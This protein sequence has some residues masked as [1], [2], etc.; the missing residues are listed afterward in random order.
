MSLAMA[1]GG[2]V[3]GTASIAILT[4]VVKTGLDPYAYCGVNWE[5][6]FDQHT[7]RNIFSNP[8]RYNEFVR[9]LRDD[10]SVR[11]F[12]YPGGT[13]VNYFFMG[14]PAT[15]WLPVLKAITPGISSA[16]P[17]DWIEVGEFFEFIKA[18]NF[19]VVLQVNTQYWF[20]VQTNEIKPVALKSDNS[21]EYRDVID[22]VGLQH[23]AAAVDQLA[24]YLRD[25]NY[26]QYVLK[27]EIGNEEN[28]FLTSNVYAS[29]VDE[30]VT[31]IRAVFPAAQIIATGPTGI[32]GDT[33]SNQWTGEVISHLNTSG[34]MSNIAGLVTHM[35]WAS[36]GTVVDSTSYQEYAGYM[37]FLPDSKTQHMWYPLYD[38][39]YHIVSIIGQMLD[40]LATW[41][42][43]GKEIWFTEYRLGGLTEY[44]STALAGAIGNTRLLAALVAAPGV[45]GAC[46]HSLLHGGYVGT[47]ILG[48]SPASALG[49]YKLVYYFADSGVTPHMVGTPGAEGFNLTARLAKGNV[50]KT[51]SSNL[52]LFTVATSDSTDIVRLLVA[53]KSSRPEKPDDVTPNYWGFVTQTNALYNDWLANGDT[54][55]A[56]ITLP[57]GFIAKSV[58]IYTLGESQTLDAYSVV[59]G[60]LNGIHEIKLE[61]SVQ[62]I[63][64]SVFAYTFKPHSTVLF[65]FSKT[66]LPVNLG[67]QVIPGDYCGDLVDVG[68]KVELIQGGTV[69]RT[70]RLFLDSGGR[71]EI[72]NVAA[73]VYNMSIQGNCWQKKVIPSIVIDTNPIDIGTVTLAGG[74][75]DGNN[76]VDAIDLSI[77]IGN[78][79]LRGN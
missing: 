6:N 26:D 44:Y 33:Y 47:L 13:Y 69:V 73:G 25:N 16:R 60:S 57:S 58:R 19:R 79:D 53:N 20:D 38:S 52:N 55:D 46:F 8:D 63:N 64:T 31:K 65:E 76:Q 36:K 12:R 11:T 45:N 5:V 24:Q 29:I 49:G 41:N 54:F 77:L 71:F 67:G 51:T 18:G 56:Q 7:Y 22:P 75:A 2:P 9:F 68:L 35:Y 30:F 74:D 3:F 14:V 66:P 21:S 61:T 72:P 1:W 78:M 10:I 27:W 43:A 32:F 40:K 4:D 62:N 59:I 39:Q 48:T 28:F 34:T 15:Q 70:E 17:D 37:S 23:A 50:L 42:A